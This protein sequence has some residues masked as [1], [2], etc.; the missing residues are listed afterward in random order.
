MT[1]A[2]R[3][4]TPVVYVADLGDAAHFYDLLDF[5]E[6]THGDDGQWAWSYLRCGELSVLLAATVGPVPEGRGPLQMYCQSDDIEGVQKRLTDAGVSVE[7]LGYPDHAPGGEIRVLDPDQHIIMMGQTTGAP[8][9][10]PTDTPDR[11]TTI[12]QRAAEAVRQRS[13]AGH[14]CQIGERGGDRCTEP[15][16]VKLTDSWGDSAWSCLRHA[17]EV[18][19]SAPGVYLATEDAEGL[20]TYLTRRRNSAAPGGR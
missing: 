11:R 4:L 5:V 1:A 9:V 3:S 19:I 12:L 15:A 10:E 18:I 20:G 14:P 13:A 16:D 2:V 7:H 17:D 6:V 8:R